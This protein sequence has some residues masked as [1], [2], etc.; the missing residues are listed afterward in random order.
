MVMVDKM[1]KEELKN[2]I[3]SAIRLVDLG[4][5]ACAHEYIE[6]SEKIANAVMKVLK[7]EGL[8]K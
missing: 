7:K 6:G 2:E 3:A 5:I 1:T 4:V 8:V